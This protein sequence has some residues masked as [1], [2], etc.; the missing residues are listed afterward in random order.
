VPGNPEGFSVPWLTGRTL[1]YVIDL[2]EILRLDFKSG[3]S[4]EIYARSNGDYVLEGYG[5]KGYGVRHD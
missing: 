4:V 5:I 2:G 3:G 1:Y